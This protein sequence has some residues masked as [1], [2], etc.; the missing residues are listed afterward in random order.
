M[1]TG[2]KGID[3]IKTFEGFRSA[4]YLC[5]AGIATIGY[6]ATFYLDSKKVTMKD[7]HISEPEASELLKKMLR[8]FE[9]AVITNCQIPINQNQFDA[10][11][12]FAYNLGAGNLK[13]ST[14]LKKVNINPKDATIKDE[15][16]KWTKAAGKV[17]PGLVA[18]REAEAKLYFTTI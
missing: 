2:S 6:G 14:L 10:L 3:L 5:P 4:P 9:N 1:A 11:V 7:K 18:R 15:F 16:M 8:S 17:L 13:T 12:S